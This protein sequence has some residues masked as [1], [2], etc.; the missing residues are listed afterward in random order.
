MSEHILVTGGAGYLGSILV[1]D[2]LEAGYKV[3]VLDN[4]M[5]RQS[6]LNHVCNN[7]AF[8]V[9]RGDI[10]LEETIIPLMKKA[11]IIIPLAA[12][13]GAP[14]CN[15]DPIGAKSVNRDAILMM[16]KHISKGQILLMPTTNSA[17]GSGGKDN[18]CT[19]ESPLNPISQ[20]A[21]DKVAIEKILM[22]H[23]N[24]ISFRLATV[25]GM[26]PRMRIDLLVNDFTYRAVHDR[27]IVLFESYFKRNYI[28]VRD[29][30]GAF[31]HAISNFNNM[32]GQ[33]YNV[34]LSDA[35]LSKQELCERI[36]LLITDFVFMDA[37][38]GVDPDQ[39]NYIVSNAKLEATGFKP[40]VSLDDGI[41]ELIKGYT[42]L[43][44]SCYGNL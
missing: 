10:R 20:Y 16:L 9:V 24:A 43:R 26:S 11:D 25:F 4:F 33:V 21:I 37:P 28:H 1:P 15:A 8:S 40:A 44:N 12:Y 29:V 5:Y 2:L 7:P 30:S 31:R 3:T 34:G 36:Q 39:R 42:M 32:K 35:N 13:V 41:A 23:Q 18:Y 27:F 6:S 38:V 19:E 14:F 17:Y 22:E